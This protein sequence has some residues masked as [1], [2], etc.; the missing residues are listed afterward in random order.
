M[1]KDFYNR[2]RALERLRSCST[3]PHMDDFADALKDDGYTWSTSRDLLRGLW[4]LGTWLDRED[5]ALHGLDDAQV[6]RFVRCIAA[7]RPSRGK[8]GQCRSAARRF[9]AWGRHQGFITTE[10]PPAVVLPAWLLD[11][12]SWMA[13]HRNV[14]PITLAGYRRPLIR[15]ARSIGNDVGLLNAPEVRAFIEAESQRAGR[16][17]AKQSITSIRSLVSYLVVT[18]QKPRELLYSIPKMP[19]WKFASLPPRVSASDVERVISSCQADT[20]M[21]CRDRAIV[22]LMARLG[23]RAG[24][25]SRLHLEDI[26]WT[27]AV[28]K[29]AGKGRRAARLPLPQDVGDAILDW[30]AVRPATD[31]AYVFLRL[32]APMGRLTS[33]GVVKATIR[34]QRRA[35]FDER[36][37]AHLLRHGAATT[38]LDEGVPLPAISALLRHQNIETTLI[39]AKVDEGLLTTVARPWPEGGAR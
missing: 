29:V 37:G 25:V 11:Y 4:H 32:P 15:L 3:G 9:L 7:T 21:G 6:E 12:E 8:L 13:V 22:L 36:T 20:P 31:E 17:A 18:G 19:R 39:Y 14:V 30:L 1:L 2:P 35:G 5:L 16:G 10:P 26:D 23:L 24:D 27:G 28:I 33:G 34:A 38:L